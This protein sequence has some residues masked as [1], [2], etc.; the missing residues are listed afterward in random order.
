[1]SLAVTFAN[2]NKYYIIIGCTI[3]VFL[4]ILGTTF[5]V[6]KLKSKKVYREGEAIVLN[7]GNLTIN[8]FDGNII[9]QRDI[10]GE[11]TIS[12]TNTSSDRSYY[13]VQVNNVIS[14]KEINIIIKDELGSELNTINK[15]NENNNL[16]SLDTID[17]SQTK[18]YKV[19]VNNVVNNEV[20]LELKVINES[21]TKMTFS[22]LILINNNIKEATTNVGKEIATTDEGLVSTKDNDGISYYFRGNVENNYVKIKDN[23]YRIV[24]INGDST[25]RIVLDESVRREAYNTNPLAAGATN[26]SLLDINNASIKLALN[27]WYNAYINEYDKFIEE[28]KYCIEKEFNNMINNY[29]YTSVYDRIMVSQKPS[30]E[31]SNELTLSKVGLLSIDEVVFAGAAKEENNKYYLYKKENNSF[32]TNSIYSISLDN[33]I[34]V[35]NEDEKGKIGEGISITQV[36][37]IRPVIN[38]SVTT[39]VKGTGTKDDPYIIVA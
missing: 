7:E 20:E 35:M 36:D 8:Y 3:L 33:N 17:G 13:T 32:L 26:E 30:L 15:F 24:R 16:I 34:Y 14:D 4:I 39:K 9:K 5:I 25:V 12:I 2:K 37:N 38:I 10:E 29:T 21:N 19:V 27:E 31:C 6:A 1:M 22:D 23:Y 18:R 11:Y 28:G